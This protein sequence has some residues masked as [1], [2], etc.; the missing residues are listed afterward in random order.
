MKKL[1]L[2]LLV[3]W[4]SISVGQSLKT[5]NVILITLDGMRWQE[6]FN[7][8]DSSLVHQQTYL[9]DSKLKEKFWRSEPK[10]SRKA[11]LPFV[12]STLAKN[13][14]LYGNRKL[15]CKVNV[16]NNQWFSYP[17][18]SELLAGHADDV[19]INS[20]NKI[21]NPNSQAKFKGK[22]AAFTS[23]DVFPYIINDKRSGVYVSGGLDEAT[24]K[25]ITE[26]ERT[27][28]QLMKSLPNPIP[29]VRPDAF[30]FYYGLEYMKKNKPRVMYFAFDE[31]DDFAH[32]GE[33]AAYLNAANYTDRFIEELWNYIQSEPAYKNKTTMILTCDH[34][35]GTN[36][37]QWK[38]HGREVENADQIWMAVIGPDTP[39]KGE[40]SGECQYYQNQ[41]AK[42]I[43]AF[44]GLQ[45]TSDQAV[46]DTM[47]S[48]MSAK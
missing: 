48:M 35:R 10:E 34:G 2:V 22:V 1:L 28:N 43:A 37:E 25:E 20:N 18:Y 38:H 24:G 47:Q 33:Y 4:S 44:L 3:I 12:W 40:V 23:W 42:T 15:G 36:S 27:L 32:Q 5:E 6:V 21:Y 9:K 8:C 7:G 16:T 13:G 41:V 26:K 46:G 11:L 19:R 17:G 29:G 14:Q 45:Y 30:T 39:P 31:T